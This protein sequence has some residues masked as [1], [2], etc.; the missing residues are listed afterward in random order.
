[1]QA[2]EGHAMSSYAIVSRKKGS[3]LTWRIWRELYAWFGDATMEESNMSTKKALFTS[4]IIHTCMIVI[5]HTTR[6]RD[7]TQVS[8]SKDVMMSMAKHTHT[9]SY[10]TEC[11]TY[12]QICA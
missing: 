1:M 9:R 6:A 11:R 3:C 10:I 12:L 8:S 7:I 4:Y 2:I 5:S